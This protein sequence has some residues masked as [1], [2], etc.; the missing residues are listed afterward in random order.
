M[1]NIVLK[2]PLIRVE[3]LASTPT[4]QRV[5]WFA[6]HQ[7]YSS[8]PVYEINTRFAE[9]VYGERLIDML[10]TGGKGHFGCLEHPQINFN[11]CF[12][13][14]STMVQAR[15]HR[16]GISFDVQSFRY[17]SSSILSI[18]TEEDLEKAFYF[19]PIGDYTDR[20]GK[21][22]HYSSKELEWDRAN[23]WEAVENYKKGIEF[24][25]S[26]EHARDRLTANYRQHMV[27]SFN[28]RSLMHFLD[29]RGKADAQ[30]EVQWLSDLLFERAL[31]W[32]PEI[33]K[34]YEEKRWKKAKLAP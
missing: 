26:E 11:C 19:R 27:V 14:H 9:R 18:E 15:T 4:P 31:E 20:Q 3:V 22:Y 16:V 33:F 32:M 8:E 7:D 10:L 5:C 29:L 1:K 2:D 12:V 21:H 23:T 6:A 25:L 17:T 30:L 28:A 34:W 13:P 24:G